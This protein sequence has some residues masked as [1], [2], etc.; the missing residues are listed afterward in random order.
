MVSRHWARVPS[1]P[2]MTEAL[3][4]DDAADSPG[5]FCME[6]RVELAVT[7]EN[8]ARVSSWS[9]QTPGTWSPIPWLGHDAHLHPLQAKRIVSEKP[10]T[11]ARTPRAKG[12]SGGGRGQSLP[13]QM[14]S[15]T[16]SSGKVY[17]QE[18]VGTQISNPHLEEAEK[19]RHTCPLPGET[20][21]RHHL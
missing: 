7:M 14:T 17:L 16:D 12:T 1:S 20:G 4:D 3:T 19:L 15:S 2:G 11:Q 5:T 18:G 6:D 21:P 13:L 8:K 9:F 10:T